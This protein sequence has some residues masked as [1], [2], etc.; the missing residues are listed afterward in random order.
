MDVKAPEMNQA[1]CGSA[2]LDQS[3]V[4]GVRDVMDNKASS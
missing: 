4:G 2:L 1:T 3:K